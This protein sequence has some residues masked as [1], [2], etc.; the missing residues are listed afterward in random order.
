MGLLD[1]L[2]LRPKPALAQTDVETVRR[3][4]EALD[5]LPPDQAR[6]VGTFSLLLARVA[7]ADLNITDDE[8]RRMEELVAEHT[9]LDAPQAALAVE[10]ARTQHRL[11]GGT[12]DYQASRE[13][14]AVTDRDQRLGVLDCLFAVAAADDSVT[15]DEEEVIRRIATE[16]GLEQTEYVAARQTVR[17]K[18]AVLKS[19]V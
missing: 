12:E 17:E 2:G 4:G 15:S 19:E 1:W 18:R 3:I 5:R 10:I 14:R 9:G 16:L 13:L 8:V 11:F 7:H 6:F